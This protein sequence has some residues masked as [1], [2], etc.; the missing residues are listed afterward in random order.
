MGENSRLGG[1]VFTAPG[2]TIGKKS[3]VSTMASVAGYIPA[4]HFVKSETNIKMVPNNF[5]GELK[6]SDLFERA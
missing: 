5:S 6:H 2:T 1:G 4:E 3:F